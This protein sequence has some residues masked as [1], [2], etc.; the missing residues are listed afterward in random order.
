MYGGRILDLKKGILGSIDIFT[1]IAM[2]TINYVECHDIYTRW[3]HI[4]LWI[5]ERCDDIAFTSE[6]IR[7]MNAL[8]AV[9]VFKSQGI[10]FI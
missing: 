4:V 10:P 5:K 9:I 8:A 3:D 7:R 6:D 2:E 1:N